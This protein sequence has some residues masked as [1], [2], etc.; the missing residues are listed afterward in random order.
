MREGEQKV[1]LMVVDQDGG[2][3]GKITTDDAMERPVVESYEDFAEAP[4]TVGELRAGRSQK[5]NDWSARDALVEMLREIDAGRLEVEHL[6][7]VY[8]E[9]TGEPEPNDRKL[10]FSA[11]GSERMTGMIGMLERA[12]MLMMGG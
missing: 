9:K 7:L 10:R 12:K 2:G 3:L 1:T 6:V 4:M 5:A 8:W 11:A